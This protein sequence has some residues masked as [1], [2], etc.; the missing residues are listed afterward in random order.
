MRERKK[1]EERKRPRDQEEQQ[2]FLS[3]MCFTSSPIN[4]D[5][6]LTSSCAYV[7]RISLQ[8]E[9]FNSIPCIE[10]LISTINKNEKTKMWKTIPVYWYKLSQWLWYGIELTWS[11]L[12]V[13]ASISIYINVSTQHRKRILSLGMRGDGEMTAQMILFKWNH[14]W[15]YHHDLG[16]AALYPGKLLEQITQSISLEQ[17]AD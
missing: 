14:F 5:P 11:M 16:K 1:R 17:K 2:N 7:R 13:S 3:F 12:K 15:I 6:A 4:H 9:H 10:V 8:K